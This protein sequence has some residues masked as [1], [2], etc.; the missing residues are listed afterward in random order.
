[1]DMQELNIPKLLNSKNE[2]GFTVPDNYFE[3]L[4]TKIQQKIKT[5]KPESKTIAFRVAPY[6]AVAASFALLVIVWQTVLE[7][8]VNNTPTPVSQNNTINDIP[9]YLSYNFDEDLLISVTLGDEITDSTD[10][11]YLAS[12]TNIDFNESDLTNYELTS[13][14]DEIM[15]YL[16]EED[17]ELSTIIEAL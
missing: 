13:D 12:E 14:E 2:T 7:M 5:N 16:I 15:L 1:M 11:I 17:I 4:P 9:E 10:L 3:Q 8:A 6:I